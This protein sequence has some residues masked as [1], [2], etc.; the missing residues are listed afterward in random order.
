VKNSSQFTNGV[1]EPGW[2]VDYTSAHSFSF[3][4]EIGMGIAIEISMPNRQIII[5]PI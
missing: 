3:L 5:R 1:Q 4:G 2:E